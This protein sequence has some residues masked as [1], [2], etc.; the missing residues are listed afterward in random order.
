MSP[1]RRALAAQFAPLACGRSTTLLG[2]NK[3]FHKLVSLLTLLGPVWLGVAPVAHAQDDSAVPLDAAWATLAKQLA[4]Q[5]ASANALP[6]ARVEVQVGQLDPR[7]RLA[8][9]QQAQAYMPAGQRLLGRTRVGLRCVKGNTLWNVT[10]PVT[11]SLFSPAWVASGP[12]PIG[13]RLKAEHFRSADIDWGATTA[14]A[15]NDITPLMGRELARPLAAGAPLLTTD[16][17]QRQWFL[18]GDTVRVLA[19]GAGFVIATEGQALSNGLEGQSVR[20]RTESGRVFS[21]RAVS[22]HQVEVAL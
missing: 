7:L 19:Q 1:I 18:A 11:V 2:V 10:L 15:F 20:V 22:A 14:E 12:L 16:L 17:R 9:C 3:S 21:G 13:T 5:A 8:P 6:S 4:T